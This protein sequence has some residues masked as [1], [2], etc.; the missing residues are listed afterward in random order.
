MPLEPSAGKELPTEV[1]WEFAARGGLVS[2]ACQ[3][4]VQNF[5]N[6]GRQRPGKTAVSTAL[7]RRLVTRMRS[8]KQSRLGAEARVL[9]PVGCQQRV[10]NKTLHA[11]ARQYPGALG[12]PADL[13]QRGVRGGAVVSRLPVSLGGELVSGLVPGGLD[14]LAGVLGE[15]DPERGGDVVGLGLGHQG[16]QVA[17]EVKP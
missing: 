11:H 3:K 10:S 4:R 5:A 14:L 17:G 16:E 2:D 8:S 7:P 15:H 9:H 13:V 1:E 12:L 6:Y